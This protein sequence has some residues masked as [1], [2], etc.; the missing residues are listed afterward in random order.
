MRRSPVRKL[1]ERII[2]AS[3]KRVVQNHVLADGVTWS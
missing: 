1:V 3:S 2:F